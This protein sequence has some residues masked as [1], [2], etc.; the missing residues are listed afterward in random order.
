[1]KSSGLRRGA[2]ADIYMPQELILVCNLVR[3]IRLNQVRNYNVNFALYLL[4]YDYIKT[5]LDNNSLSRGNAKL[6]NLIKTEGGSV[7]SI[8]QAKQ[9]KSSESANK[10]GQFKMLFEDSRVLSVFAQAVVVH[11]NYFLKSLCLKQEN[12]CIKLDGFVCIVLQF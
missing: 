5:E 3:S 6:M 1:M 4:T 11:F 7:L 2:L 8:L 9:S 12:I 10:I